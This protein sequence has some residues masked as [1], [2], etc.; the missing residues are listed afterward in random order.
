MGTEVASNDIVL[1]GD[2]GVYGTTGYMLVGGMGDDSSSEI[3]AT[4]SCTA[5][6]ATT[7]WRA[8]GGDD[9]YILDGGGHDTIE[10]KAG[11]NRVL[12]NGKVLCN[13]TSSDGTNYLSADGRFTGVMQNG[14]FIVI[15]TVT[16]DQVTLDQNF[17]SGDSASSSTT[18]PPTSNTP[19]LSPV[20]SSPMTSI[21]TRSASRLRAMRTATRSAPPAPT[22]IFWAARQ[23]TTIS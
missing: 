7:S 21:R 11:N 6:P 8:A 12:L 1:A 23:A 10:D 19:P 14:D 18:P 22:K 15:D 16:G 4:T 20:T 5:A 17:Q 13:F 3:A 2:G 9:T